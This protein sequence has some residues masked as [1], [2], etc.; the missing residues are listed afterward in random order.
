VAKTTHPT[1]PQTKYCVS[2]PTLGESGP[3][4]SSMKQVNHQTSSSPVSITWVIHI[5]SICETHLLFNT[6]TLKPSKR[7]RYWL[8]NCLDLITLPYR[9]LCPSI[10]TWEIMM[11]TTYLKVIVN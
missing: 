3:L 6:S 4:F 9:T 1:W 11:T 7:T 8:Q 2:L 10:M 5:A